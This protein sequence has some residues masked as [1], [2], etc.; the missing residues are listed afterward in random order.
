[1]DICLYV[2]EENNDMINI[3]AN[4]EENKLNVFSKDIKNSIKKS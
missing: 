2:Q 4:T 3:G 1:M